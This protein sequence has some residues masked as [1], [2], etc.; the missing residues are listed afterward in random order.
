MKFIVRN[1]ASDEII[2]IYKWY[3]KVKFNLGEEFLTELDV[4]FEYIQ[5]FPE[6]FEDK[7]K[8]FR[9]VSVKRFPYIV[10][11][12]LFNNAIVVFLVRSTNKDNNELKTILD[13]IK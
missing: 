2:A 1:E 7:Y 6:G 8:S 13:Q 4:C 12:E 11:Y 10:I 3:E 9:F 5:K